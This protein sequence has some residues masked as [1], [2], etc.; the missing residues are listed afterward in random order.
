MNLV[1]I[2]PPGAGKGTHATLLSEKYSLVP[3]AA[4]DILR[5]HIRDQ[6]ELGQKAKNIIEQG[7]LVSDDLVNAMMF[8]EIDKASKKGVLLDGYPRTMGQAEAL[9]VYLDKAQ[10]KIDAVLNFETSEE[11]IVARLSGRR[12]CPKCGANYHLRNPLLQP[13]ADGRCDK[14][15]AELTQR[16]DDQPETIRHRLETYKNETE[17]LLGYYRKKKILYDLHGDWDV[18]EFQDEIK[19]LFEKLQLTA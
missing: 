6:S 1:L 8:E 12:V 17:P 4:G 13:K 15:D 11:M 14:C 16:K 19:V 9:D 10:A 3:L 5:R 7:G 18:L 2:G